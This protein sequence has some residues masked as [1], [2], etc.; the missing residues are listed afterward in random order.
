MQTLL[1]LDKVL[2]VG[3]AVSLG[4]PTTQSIG[5]RTSTEHRMVLREASGLMA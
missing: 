2:T 4:L 5:A 1:P 3:W